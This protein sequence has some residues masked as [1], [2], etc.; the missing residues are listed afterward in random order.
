VSK[1]CRFIFLGLPCS[2]FCEP[3]TEKTGID[4]LKY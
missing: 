4:G 3:L 1:R 2:V